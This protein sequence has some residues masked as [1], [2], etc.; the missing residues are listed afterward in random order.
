LDILDQRGPVT[1][2]VLAGALGLSPSAVTTVIDR[3]ERLRYVRRAPSREDRRQV[4]VELTPLLRRRASELYG[5]G[6]EEGATLERYSVA[7]LTLLRDFVRRD[8]LLNERRAE[9][10]ARPPDRD[11]RARGGT[12]PG[13]LANEIATERSGQ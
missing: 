3:L 8:R 12:G 6:R 10:L 13:D 7:E 5:A 2:G 1:A 4:L 9:K 11:R